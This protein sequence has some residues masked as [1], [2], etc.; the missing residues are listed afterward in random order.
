MKI[1]NWYIARSCFATLFLSVGLLTFA[2]VGSRLIEIFKY[3]AQGG[4]FMTAGKMLICFFPYAMALAIPLGFLV[5]IMLIFGRLSADS[6][7]TAMRACGISIMQIISPVIMMAFLLS[8]LCLS[9]QLHWSPIYADKARTAGRDVLSDE[10]LAL[11]E[12]GMQ[13]SISNMMIY[14]EE[15]TDSNIIKN[16]DILRTSLDSGQRYFSQF[17]KAET[18]KVV[19][20]Q[21][22]KI[23]NIT[24]D[25]AIITS[26]EGGQRQIFSMSEFKL[27]I[28]YSSRTN[29]NFLS[30]RPKYL[31]YTDIF[32]RMELLADRL[33]D[34]T[35]PK[36]VEMVEKDMCALSVE[37]NRRFA[38][39]LSPIAFLL[40]G[41]P[42]AIRSSRRET[43]VGL[44][45][46]FSLSLAY[47]VSVAIIGQLS[48]FP[49]IHPEYLLWLPVVLYQ[50]VGGYLL[51][52]L[53]RY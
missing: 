2:V 48:S 9:L 43:S 17:I 14:V 8:F 39:G 10:P 30:K 33:P 49:S 4:G 35:D 23:L 15:R 34:L 38:L 31:S 19:P 28:D 13:S 45:I 44:I 50:A 21:R 18:G 7:I 42:L 40:L 51:W 46:A 1:L 24:L 5:T 20:D 25:D 27:A 32:G 36:A 16:V 41:L 53:T 26:Y 3:L 12:P 11:I 52:R 6:E 29:N 47:L 22:N 37:I